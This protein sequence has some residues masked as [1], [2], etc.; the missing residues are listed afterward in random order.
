VPWGD[1]RLDLSGG[2]VLYRGVMGNYIFG[3]ICQVLCRDGSLDLL[4][5]FVV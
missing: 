1:G 2:F 4:G 5:G 3:W